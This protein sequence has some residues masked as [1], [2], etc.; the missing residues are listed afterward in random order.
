MVKCCQRVDPLPP[1]A[2][3]IKTIQQA[4]TAEEQKAPEAS[5]L[6]DWRVLQVLQPPFS[7][8]LLHPPGAGEETRAP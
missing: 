2:S 4:A 7:V 3:L 8:L 1:P 5:G 6:L